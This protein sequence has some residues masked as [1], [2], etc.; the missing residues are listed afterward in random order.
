MAVN[1][2]NLEKPDEKWL[3]DI[4]SQVKKAAEQFFFACKNE[5]RPDSCGWLFFQRDRIL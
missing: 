1:G 2:L 3:L 5:A 4:R